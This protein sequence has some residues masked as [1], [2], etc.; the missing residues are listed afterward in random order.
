MQ[1]C[2]EVSSQWRPTARAAQWQV[3]GSL[4]LRQ[5]DLLQRS[6]PVIALP[7]MVQAGLQLAMRHKSGRPARGVRGRPCRQQ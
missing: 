2:H 3:E 4:H 1:L 6:S 5:P 7:S